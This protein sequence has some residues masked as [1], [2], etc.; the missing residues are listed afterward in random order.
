MLAII[1]GVAGAIALFFGHLGY[2]GGPVMVDLPATAPTPPALHGT[3]A[4]LMSGDL[5]FNI[6]IGPQVAKKLRADGI[7]VVGVNSLTAF[8]HKQTPEQVQALVTQAATHAL[9]FAHADRLILIGQSFG[10]DML[11]VGL[12]ALPPALRAKV[13]LVAL[14]VPGASVQ[15]RASPSDVFTFNISSSDA[16]P[17][18][19]LLDWAPLL[20]IRGAQ[21]TDSLCPLLKTANVRTAI[22]PGGHPLHRDA[23]AVHDV[24]IDAIRTAA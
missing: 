9:A 6:G 18:A 17:T 21:E 2:F 24:L 4:V 19:H 10:A 11:H 13:R 14:V 23:G 16:L 3:V 22:L 15:F 5:G 8:R 12:P 1:G 20:C 7:P